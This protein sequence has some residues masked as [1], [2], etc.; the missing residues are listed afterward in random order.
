MIPD[1]TLRPITV[2]PGPSG[3]IFVELPYSH[4]RVQK[5][6]TISG[7]KWNDHRHCWAIPRTIRTIDRLKALFSGDQIILDPELF[8]KKSKPIGWQPA[9]RVAPGPA[10]DLLRTF[11]DV[12]VQEAYSPHTIKIYTFHTRRFLKALKNTPTDIQPQDIKYYLQHLQT[13]DKAA[14]TY[15]RQ[16]IRA[17]KA[18]C[19]LALHKP[20]EFVHEAFPPR[21][22]NSTSLS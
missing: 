20:P 22:K 21:E 11:K 8:K 12:L 13:K 5:I 6:K 15:T 18:L 7:R 4:E 10:S 17:L 9:I 2:T 3:W 19:R 1:A 16:A 14:E